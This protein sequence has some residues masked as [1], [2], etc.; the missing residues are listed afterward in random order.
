LRS[1]YGAAVLA[2]VSTQNKILLGG[3]A[4]IFIGFALLSSFVLPR[5]NPNF[6]GHRLGL[7]LTI[8]VILF[9]GMMLAVEL[10]AVEEEEP[11]HEQPAAVAGG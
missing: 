11:G 9:A 5:R 3:M 8:T 1:K 6:P 4:A 10:F 2:A 7:F